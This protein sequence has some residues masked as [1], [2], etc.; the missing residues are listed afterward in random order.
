M[1]LH[2]SSPARVCRSSLT[3]TL[4]RSQW[5][6]GYASW[7]NTPV[8][9]GFQS[10]TGYLQGQTDYF[11]KTSSLSD[12]F[13]HT[14]D[15][16]G[17]DFWR[18]NSS[19]ADSPRP[20]VPFR[21]AAGTYSLDNYMSAAKEL[22]GGFAERQRRDPDKRMFLCPRR[23]R[24]RTLLQ[25]WEAAAVDHAPLT[26]AGT[27][28]IRRCMTR[29]SRARWRRAARWRTTGGAGSGTRQRTR[30]FRGCAARHCDGRRCG[31]GSAR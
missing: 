26:P 3:S 11:N 5:H 17:F 9:R 1:R 23:N 30:T 21:K 31:A 7:K 27:W 15:H 6:V 20:C 25:G 10:F 13:F 24:A 28:R 22:I 8:G 19:L 12:A 2:R 16:Q 14:G 4:P 18:C 29:L